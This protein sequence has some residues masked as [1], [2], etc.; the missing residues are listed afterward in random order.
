ME[1]IEQLDNKSFS[2]SRFWE[3][4]KADF[5]L[6]KNSYL[7]YFIA[8]IGCYV[9]IASMI[10]FNAVAALKEVAELKHYTSS[11]V[12]SEDMIRSNYS[13]MLFFVSLFVFSLFLTIKG[14]QTFSN[15]SDKKHRISAF[16]LPASMSEKFFL[17]MFIYLVCGTLLSLI[18]LSIGY[19]VGQFS[20][21]AIG[22]SIDQI[23]DF[24]ENVE[25]AHY[26]VVMFVLFMFLQNALFSLGSSLWPKLSWLKTWILL[27]V[28]QWIFG[29]IMIF[30]SIADVNWYSFLKN[31]DKVDADLVCWCV[32]SA[33]ILLIAACW[34][35]AWM[36]FR[37]TQIVQRFMKK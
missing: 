27:T 2:S 34:I 29:I 18:G 30:L 5:I 11:L 20:F 19:L 25:L 23:H 13:A 4:L 33:E 37:S 17:R 31:L 3:L 28:I 1:R 9:A 16:M 36:R 12:D 21:G 26:I 22:V 24:F 15:L 32:I 10:S 35:I 7:K 6:N 8:I 14:S